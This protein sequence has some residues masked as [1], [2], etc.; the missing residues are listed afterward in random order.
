MKIV[1]RHLTVKPHLNITFLDIK[2]NKISYVPLSF[3]KNL[4]WHL[5]NWINIKK[6]IIII[7]IKKNIKEIKNNNNKLNYFKKKKKKELKYFIIVK[8][9]LQTKKITL[10][11]TIFGTFIMIF[12]NTIIVKMKNKIKNHKKNLKLWLLKIKFKRKY[13]KLKNKI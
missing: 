11:W 8:Y 5:G 6:A 10:E 9:F 7:K 4:F 3:A 2:I 12:K 13:L 1:S